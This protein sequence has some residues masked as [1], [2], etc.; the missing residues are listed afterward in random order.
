M[1]LLMCAPLRDSNGTVKYFIGAQVDVTQPFL[2][3]IG[4]ESMQQP[5][6]QERRQSSAENAEQTEQ[7]EHEPDEFRD[8]VELFNDSEIAT[9]KHYGGHL[10]RGRKKLPVRIRRANARGRGNHQRVLIQDPTPEREESPIDESSEEPVEPPRTGGGLLKGVYQHYL[11]VRPYP[12]LR[13]LFTSPSLRTPGIYQMPFMDKVGGSIRVKT[14]LVD[15]LH[16]GNGVTAKITW[17]T[18]RDTDEGR[19]RWAHCTPLFDAAGNV[20]VWMVVLV[21]IQNPVYF[22]QGRSQG[23]NNGLEEYGPHREARARARYR[24]TLDVYEVE[25][26]QRLMSMSPSPPNAERQLPPCSSRMPPTPPPRTSS[27]HDTDLAESMGRDGFVLGVPPPGRSS[28]RT[29]SHRSGRR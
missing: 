7:V 29:P 22:S 24:E 26:A 19:E 28:S 17:I 23:R 14:Q 13:I 2:E 9:A 20:G 1:N 27:R 6:G 16:A 8:L 25:H 3:N 18:N 11:L 21:D 5:D 10:H 15:A 12:S 4:L